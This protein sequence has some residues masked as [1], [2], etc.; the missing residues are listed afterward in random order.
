MKESL[1]SRVFNFINS[2]KTTGVN[3]ES[4]FKKFNAESIKSILKE[5]NL[6]LKCGEIFQKN[7]ILFSS[8]NFNLI[9]AKITKSFNKFCFASSIHSDINYFISAKF[10]KNALFSDIVL[11]KKQPKNHSE[12][13]YRSKDL[14]KECSVFCI[15][16]KKNI[17]FIGTVVSLDSGLF[18]KPDEFFDCLFKINNLSNKINCYDKVLAKIDRLTFDFYNPVCRIIKIFGNSNKAY[19]CAKAYVENSGVPIEFPEKVLNETSKFKIAKNKTKNRLDLTKQTVFTIDSEKAKDLDDAVSIKKTNS[20]YM[21]GVHIADVSN[22]VEFKSK[23]DKEALLRGNSIYIANTVIPMLPKELSDNLCSLLPNR[24]RLTFSVLICLD[25]DGNVV[26]F[27][28]VKSKINSKIKGIYE[29]INQILSGKYDNIKIKNKLNKKYD[30]VKKSLILMLELC[31]KLKTKRINRGCPQLQSSECEIE[32]NEQNNVIKI[33]KKT[34][35]LSEQLIEELMLLANECVAK[36]ATTNKLKI[37]YR[38]HEKPSEEKVEDFKKLAHKLGLNVAKIKPNLKPKVLANLIKQNEHSSFFPVL[39]SNILKTMAKAKYSAQQEPHYGLALKNYTHFTSP[40]R[41]YCD[42]MVHRILTE[43][44]YNK[45]K[46][47]AL[48]KKYAN[49]LNK[50]AKIINKT[51]RTAIKLERA[52]ESYF[53]AEFMCDKIGQEFDAIIA[54]CNKNGMFVQLANTIEGFV[55]IESLNGNFYF[56]GFFKLISKNSNFQFCTGQK[57]KVKCVAAN[58]SSKTIDFIVCN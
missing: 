44:L 1:K 50:S 52:C 16:E 33:N 5:I 31:N 10:S 37:F 43:F 27:K 20:G 3:E 55:K 34:Q 9:P 13:V 7:D 19:V 28:I 32:L 41:R 12:S 23:T 18:V 15:C 25:F 51:E 2:T 45:N 46:P 36:Y 56:D 22:F 29:E 14:L 58:V 26:N 39:N 21:V 30:K 17:K 42:L 53:K 6:M 48:N 54:S 49:F 11:L 38:V 4:I 57:I 35:G 40:I 24:V 8:Q 47:K